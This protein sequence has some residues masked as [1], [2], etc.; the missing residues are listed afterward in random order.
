MHI[1]HLSIMVESHPN[2]LR[3]LPSSDSTALGFFQ[4]IAGGFGVPPEVDVEALAGF[5][6]P[7]ELEAFDLGF[8]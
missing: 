5:A 6:A 1:C 8:V 3:S 4:S 2:F 7:E